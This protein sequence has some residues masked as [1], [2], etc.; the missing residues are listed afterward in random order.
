MCGLE[1]QAY[2]CDIENTFLQEFVRNYEV[3]ATNC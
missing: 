1:N 2:G 3:N